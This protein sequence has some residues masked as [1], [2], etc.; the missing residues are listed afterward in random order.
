M[1]QILFVL[2]NG[3]I[4]QWNLSRGKLVAATVRGQHNVPYSAETANAY[5]DEWKEDN[6]VASGDV[7][8]AIFLSE[9]QDGFGELP[10]WICANSKDMSAWTIEQLSLLANESE[11]KEKGL[12]FVQG[13]VKRLIGTEKA[14]GA[15][16]LILKSSFAFTLPKIEP[17]PRVPESKASKQ[18][19]SE[20]SSAPGNA[21]SYNDP[22]AMLL[23][24]GDK[25]EG[26]VTSVSSALNRCYIKSDKAEQLIRVKLSA[27]I[28]SLP[29][30][31]KDKLVGKRL[32]AEVV[33]VK[34]KRVDYWVAF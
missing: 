33:S 27:E 28:A 9:S 1:E 4:S 5:W 23:K 19:T 34:D 18:S 15:I 31:E 2:R 17:K 3:K 20:V 7:Y 6:M 10:K 12:C 14:D 26:T 24:V 8:D 21:D 13:N 11:Y 16:K 32:T 30:K 22:K 29:K 25:V